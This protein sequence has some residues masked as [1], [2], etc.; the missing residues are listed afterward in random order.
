MTAPALDGEVGILHLRA[1]LVAALGTGVLRVGEDRVF[2]DGGF[3]EVL[4]DRVLVLAETAET[5]DEIDLERARAAEKRAR[6]RL[7]EGGPSLDRLRA[8]RALAR[9]KGRLAAA[10]A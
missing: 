7:A 6:E 1:P 9:A 2:V 5:A 3:V 10:S 8:R 4:N